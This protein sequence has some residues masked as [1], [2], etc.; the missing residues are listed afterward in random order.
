[1][2]IV[3]VFAMTSSVWA[4]TNYIYPSFNFN[5][6]DANF[7]GHTYTIGYA[8]YNSQSWY[9]G[10]LS[11]GTS[12]VYPPN[13]SSPYFFSSGSQVGVLEPT[14]PFAKNCYRILVAVQR[15]DGIT[16]FGWS[17][18]TDLTGLSNGSLTIN[19]DVF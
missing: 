16:K 8:I 12:A 11:V 7:S 1:M 19:V 18:W 13:P 15:D 10:P 14:P 9:I 2:L 6:R 17:A 5:Y 4:T 3:L